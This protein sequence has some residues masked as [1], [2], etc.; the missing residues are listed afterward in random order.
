MA[1]RRTKTRTHR[2]VL[3]EE[4]AQIPR[5]MVLRL[6][7]SLKNRSLAQLV[8]D[9]RLCMQ[10]HTAINLRER[11]ANRLKDFVVMAGPLGVSEMFVFSQLES[12]GNI[13][14]RLGKMPRGPTLQF[15]VNSYSLC[16]DVR[17]MLKRPKLAGRDA[18]EFANPP[19]LVMNGFTKLS[20]AP[21]HEKLM[22]TVFQNLFPPIEPQRTR[23]SGIRRV[24]MLNKDKE[25]GAI[26][27][28]HFAI[29]TKLVNESR[30]VKK[31]VE[32]HRLNKK[33][34]NLARS[35][36]VADLLLDPYSVGGITSD[37][38]VED[39]A[40]VEI[41]NESA[42]P[43]LNAAT[44]NNA[45]HANPPANSTQPQ[46]RKRA[47]KLTELGPRINMSLVKIEEGLV[48][49]S[50]TIYHASI[51]KLQI[52]EK[53]LEKRHMQKQKLKQERTARQLENLK[54][55]NATK[56]AKKARRKARIAGEDV[57]GADAK[58]ENGVV[59]MDVDEDDD[60][61]IDAPLINPQD[62]ED[63]P[64]LFDDDE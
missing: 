32:S 21:N 3:K 36:D 61:D 13:S 38:E 33:L 55:K 47:I 54:Q 28:R 22:V 58:S 64:D 9:V 43:V 40:V 51:T 52:E 25:T 20:E 60:E 56:D 7:S 10:P 62:Y 34:P 12:T 17:N 5:L 49:S 19:L 8:R 53:A 50:K 41:N 39:D 6:G 27:L 11:K 1:K 63:D 2:K 35:S 23:V 45:E 29:S 18:A 48:G 4:L 30:N 46:T 14:L 16:K 44:S 31:L 59:D 24:L 26:D 42:V 15:K 37:S 57:Q